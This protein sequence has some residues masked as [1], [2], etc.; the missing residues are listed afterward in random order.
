MS[1]REELEQDA[2]ASL[3]LRKAIIVEPYTLI[4]AAIAMMR[5]ASLG[6]AVIV[7]YGRKPS[8]I[9]TEHSVIDALTKNVSLD[10]S[11]ICHFADANF[12]EVKQ[13]EPIMRVWEAVQLAAARFVCVT[14][15]NGKVIGIT[16]QRGL[17]EYLAETCARQVSVQRLG[18]KPWMSQREGA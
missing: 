6:C 12:I 5:H 16:G 17:S 1:F 18:S 9:F 2:V 15:E 14:D 13:T 7:D 10:E 3:P 11:P 4:R 8:G